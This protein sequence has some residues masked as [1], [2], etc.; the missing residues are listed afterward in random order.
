MSALTR[1]FASLVRNGI[2]SIASAIW[3]P[4]NEKGIDRIRP[5][6]AS[7]EVYPHSMPE[8]AAVRM[9]R[10]LMVLSENHLRQGCIR[11]M[12]HMA[13]MAIETE[14]DIER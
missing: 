12:R 5:G 3:P 4:R 11:A 13:A 7:K 2:L 14:A 10:R 1:A 6:S 9:T 8:K